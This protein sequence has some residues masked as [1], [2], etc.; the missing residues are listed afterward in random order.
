MR[1]KR[2]MASATAI[3]NRPMPDRN[4]VAEVYIG[5]AADGQSRIVTSYVTA[6]QNALRTSGGTRTAV[7]FSYFDLHGA[8]SHCMNALSDGR[9][10]V[11][12]GHSWGSDTALKIAHQLPAPVA[13]L[14]GVDP[15]MRHGSL[16]MSVSKKPRNAKKVVHVD[17]RPIRPDRSDAVKAIGIVMGLG[18]APAFRH[19]DIRIDTQLNHWAF[20][21]MIEAENSVGVSLR[22][23]INDVNAT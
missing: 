2:S 19:A 18:L 11:L 3:P 17:A 22:Q 14:A 6:R 20:A 7:W 4:G 9:E 13:L 10:V 15:V 8:L 1:L 16:F 12:V 5:G 21:H 23:L